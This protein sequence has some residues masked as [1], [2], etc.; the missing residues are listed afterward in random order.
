MTEIKTDL[1]AL[2]R[3]FAD[4]VPLPMV[5]VSS[6]IE[7]IRVYCPATQTSKAGPGSV[8]VRYKT[9]HWY[10]TVDVPTEQIDRLR[11]AMLTPATEV[12]RYVKRE[13]H[14]NGAENWGVANLQ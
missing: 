14:V 6:Q 12:S 3:H 2:Q 10:A 1:E 11:E 8:F 13:F 9:G 5:A 4:S 7:Q